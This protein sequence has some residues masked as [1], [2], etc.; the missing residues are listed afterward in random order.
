MDRLAGRH[1]GAPARATDGPPCAAIIGQE[2]NRD[3]RPRTEGR[4]GDAQGDAIEWLYDI[5]L[6]GQVIEEPSALTEARPAVFLDNFNAKEL[7]SDMLASALT[8][9]PAMVRPFGHT[10]NVPLYIC[11]FIGITGN[12]VEIAEDMARRVL[13]APLDARMEDPEERKFDPGFLD[14]VFTERAACSP[15]C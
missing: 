15:A 8:E 9:N 3:G 14:D 6:V 4:D 12:G 7:E 13:E 2:R 10:K 5:G 1:R 11:T